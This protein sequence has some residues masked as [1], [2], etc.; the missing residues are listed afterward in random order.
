ME[1]LNLIATNQ[2]KT[3]KLYH[4]RIDMFNFRLVHIIFGKLDFKTWWIIFFWKTKHFDAA[5]DRARKS[6]LK[7]S[8]ILVLIR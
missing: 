6:Y 8:L 7:A 2:I 5:K 3:Y 1:D 4:L